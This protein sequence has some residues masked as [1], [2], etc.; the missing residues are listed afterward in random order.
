MLLLLSV[1]FAAGLLLLWC[2]GITLA[3]DGAVFGADAVV[4]GTF[5]LVPG[6]AVAGSAVAAFVLSCCS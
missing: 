4:G 3:D 2:S 6:V 1:V 5:V